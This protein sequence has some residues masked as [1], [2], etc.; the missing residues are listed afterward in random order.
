MGQ[1][2]HCAWTRHSPDSTWT[3]AKP[4]LATYPLNVDSLCRYGAP[5]SR[6]SR[7]HI[8]RPPARPGAQAGLQLSR[9]VAR[10]R[11]QAPRRQREHARHRVPVHRNGARARRTAHRGGSVESAP[12]RT[13]SADRPA[14]HD[15]DA[16]L[17]RSH[18]A[19]SAAGQDF[20]LHEMHRR[21]SGGRRAVHGAA[22][23]RHAVS[24]VSRA[25]LA[26]RARPQPGRSDVP[27]S[28]EHAR[29]VQRPPD[30]GDVSLGV[31]QHL[32]R[33]AAI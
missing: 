24:V 22:T 32:S 31:G 6:E 17:R 1:V 11:G 25:R 28:V 4:S 3:G 23:G 18:A 27:V 10:R 20:V 8:P 29:H 33:S 5:M 16:H 7:L 26:D 9:D 19:H 13:R 15:A 14:A 21:G 2:T 30:A 12:R